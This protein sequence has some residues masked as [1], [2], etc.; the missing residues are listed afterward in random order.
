MKIACLMMQKNETNL[1]KP[2]IEY[3]SMIFGIKNIFVYD[4]GSTDKVCIDI[5]K[6][7]EAKGLS[8]EW[9]FNTKN[10][11]ENK[12]RIFSD[13]IKKLDQSTSP[14]D[15]YFPL[16]CDEFIAYERSPGDLLVDRRSIELELENY[17]GCQST[18]A[19]NAGYDNNPL[20]DQ[21]YFRSDEQRK[22]FFYKDTCMSLDMGFHSGKTHLGSETKK[23]KIVYIHHHYKEFHNY[24]VSAK[25]K[26]KGRVTDFSISSL[27]MHRDNKGPGYHLIGALL[28]TEEEYYHS[29]YTNFSS[30]TN[31]H[32][33]MEFIS[34]YLK[35]LGLN[36]TAPEHIKIKCAVNNSIR[37][38]I[39]SIVI[40]NGSIK[41]TGWAVVPDE[42]D[43]ISIYLVDNNE[44]FIKL[45][46]IEKYSRP[47]VVRVVDGAKINCGIYAEKNITERELEFIKF[48]EMKVIVKNQTMTSKL[49]FNIKNI[50]KN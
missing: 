10:D 2:W 12:G 43:I 35:G 6:R 23:T 37:G 40:S 39:D 47:D 1:L 42:N 31:K 26:L 46:N 24:Q 18:L 49:S 41:V 36:I 14:Y 13:R 45:S 25:E 11:F 8:V 20:Y 29:F 32:H 50:L 17:I 19:I 34:I 9:A 7:Y 21:F 44:K 16:D 28:T 3:H 27:K 38:V 48:D 22:T 15:F 5:L 33:N 30:H 4:N